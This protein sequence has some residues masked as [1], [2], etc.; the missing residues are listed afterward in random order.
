MK[1]ILVITDP[2]KRNQVFVTDSLE[3]LSLEK[4]IK[5]TKEGNIPGIHIVKGSS[6]TYLRTNREVAKSKELESLSISPSQFFSQIKNLNSNIFKPLADY[7]EH[8]QKSLDPSNSIIIRAG[9]G[10][11]WRVITKGKAK[12]KLEQN[13]KDIFEAAK[14]FDIDPYTIG[15]I[16]I[17]EMARLA[18][19]EEMC[20]LLLTKYIGVNTSLGIAQIKIKT[21]RELIK[22][23][24]YNPNP[25]DHKLS[26]SQ[27]SSTSLLHISQYL[28]QPKHSI[29]FC[30][31]RIRSL[32]DK[33]KS[34]V[35][36]S[37]LPEIIGT[38]Y[39]LGGKDPHSKP[40][41]SDRGSQIGK[42]FY[43]L[44]KTFLSNARD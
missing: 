25:R 15:A 9:G 10:S 24:Y 7:L 40:E 31:A 8:S 2:K 36:I 4:A 20:N 38:L 28:L 44:A 5:L 34:S 19:F 29:F 1:I 39:S 22:S 35:D 37:S 3:V 27:I 41:S 12:E 30:A 16:L 11:T 13:K 23:G 17:D 26:K 43:N 42:E 32:I 33:W 21:A 6:G 14:Q 18:L